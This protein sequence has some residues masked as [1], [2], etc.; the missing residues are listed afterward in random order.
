M[1]DGMNSKCSQNNVGANH[2]PST[3]LII[4]LQMEVNAHVRTV[5]SSMVLKIKSVALRWPTSKMSP[6]NHLQLSK[7]TKPTTFSVTPQALKV[8]T[9]IQDKI[10]SA[11]AMTEPKLMT[12]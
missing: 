3:S 11:T 12:N 2:K 10:K 8:L 7:Q 6:N 5:M 9:Q 4:A 1:I